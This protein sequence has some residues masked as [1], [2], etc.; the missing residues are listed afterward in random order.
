VA[1]SIAGLALA[2]CG[3]SG[4]SDASG[5]SGS[6]GSSDKGCQLVSIDDVKA[7]F[8]DEGIDEEQAADVEGSSDACEFTGDVKAGVMGK[9]T[10]PTT[11][12]LV[13]G[14]YDDDATGAEEY[15]S[16][17][18]EVGADVQEIDGFKVAAGEAKAVAKFD[19][20]TYAFSTIASPELSGP[21]NDQT[22]A[23]LELLND[24]N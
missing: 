12:A 21:G 17:S 9:Y 22:I 13:V 20:G 11:V 2:G 8:P 5:S 19:D 3:S 15:K 16:V 10:G 6:S 18:D 7:A 24:Q 4:G 14:T 1:L 23:M